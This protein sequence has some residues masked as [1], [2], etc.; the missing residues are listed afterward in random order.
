MAKRHGFKYQERIRKAIGKEH[1]LPASAPIKDT[2]YLTM[3]DAEID[4]RYYT[5]GKADRTR[6]KK[7][8]AVER[9]RLKVKLIL[10]QEQ[11]IWNSLL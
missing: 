3:T 11:A 7:L 4:K 8:A 2:A 5:Y 6:L 1:R 10:E 9:N